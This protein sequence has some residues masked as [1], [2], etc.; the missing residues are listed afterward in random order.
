MRIFQAVTLALV[1]AG[2]PSLSFAEEGKAKCACSDKCMKACEKGPNRNC[3]CK[4][5]DCAKG[6]SC[7]H[8]KCDHDHDHGS[9]KKA[10]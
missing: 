2:S 5:C 10:E 7:S 6:A 3:K 9:E 1:L 4:A 8:E